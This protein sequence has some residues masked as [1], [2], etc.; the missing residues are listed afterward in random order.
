VGKEK[1]LGTKCRAE[2]GVFPS[3][4]KKLRKT[5]LL[6][7]SWGGEKEGD[8]LERSAKVGAFAE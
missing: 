8:D 5:G 2:L 6:A 4:S 7:P 3:V 1:S